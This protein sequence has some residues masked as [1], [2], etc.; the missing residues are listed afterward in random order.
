MRNMLLTTLSI[1]AGI[2]LYAGIHHFLVGAHRRPDPTHLWF[3]VLSLC[4]TAYVLAKLAA[5]SA[6][7]TDVLV[8]ARRAELSFAAL[9]LA[10]LPWFVAAYT[11]DKRRLLLWVH[12][13]LGAAIFVINIWLPY[14]ISFIESPTL[15]YFTLPWG[16]QVVDLRVQQ[17][18]IWHNA[19]WLY[20]LLSFVVSAFLCVIHYQR[21]AKRRAIILAVALGVFLVFVLFNR[22]VNLGLVNFTHTAEFGFIALIVLMNA[23]LSHELRSSVSA[24]AA[25]EARLRTLTEHAADGIFLLDLEG[26]FVDMNQQA[27]T[28]L[29][30]TRDAL[31][32][33]N[34]AD[35]EVAID[36]ARLQSIWHVMRPGAPE[37]IEGTSR[38]KDGSTFPSEVRVGL[39]QCEGRTLVLAIVRDITER[40]RTEKALAISEERLRATLDNTPGVAVQWFDRTGRVLYW[41]TASEKLY[42]IPAS[43]AVGATML[44]LLHTPEQFNEFLDFIAAIETRGTPYGPAEIDIRSAVGA[45]VTV[46]Y[47]MFMIPGATNEPIFVCMDVDITDR[48]RAENEVRSLN[49]SLEQRV[50]ERTVQL[51]AAYKELE[52]FSYSVSHDLR[53]PLRGIDGF[54]HLLAEDYAPQLDATARGYV[55]RIR[56]ATQHMGRLID[57]MLNLSRLARAEMHHETV[58]LSRLAQETV[59]ELERAEPDRAVV[60]SIAPGM[61][62][63]GD[64]TLLRVVLNNLLGNAWKYTRRT[65]Q[66]HIEFGEVARDGARCFYVR[67]NGVGFDMQY[68]GKLFGPFQRLHSAQDFEGSGIGLA[69]VAR[70]VARH[71]GRI[72]AESAIDTGATFYFT[73]PG[74]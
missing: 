12:S 48:K 52:A 63:A 60:A 50:C 10:V 34:V 46:L 37:T 15:H 32:H 13:G 51:E 74:E 59:A 1:L 55:E 14:G 69:T 72:W 61:T 35:I 44:D 17:R 36:F 5:Y 25:S 18:S 29:G 4:I 70:I 62:A 7:S 49:A 30:Y 28:S 6:G 65:A 45:E 19:A 23:A 39:F 54:S 24:L 73:L 9:A 26:R 3:A 71:G 66:P 64:V 38:R 2:C 53:A 68:A 43:Q 40:K 11:D 20:V 31:L 56:N 27:C 57:D 58:D 67:D 41:N 42:A 33:M 47:T 8:G 16:E 21:G 22:V